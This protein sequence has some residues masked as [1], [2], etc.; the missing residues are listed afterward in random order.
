MYSIHNS[1]T[2]DG[3]VLF[4]SQG[5][6]EPQVSVVFVTTIVEDKSLRICKKDHRTVEDTDKHASIV[7]V[8][9][10]RL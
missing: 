4:V 2:P 9:V 6:R 8:L 10:P 1:V 3:F 5:V 7:D